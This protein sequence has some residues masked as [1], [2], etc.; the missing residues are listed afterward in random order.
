[1]T[2]LYLSNPQV[3]NS[4]ELMLCFKVTI[5]NDNEIT[6]S[7]HYQPVLAFSLSNLAKQI[8]VKC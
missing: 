6:I 3:I 4:Q 7:A 5:K 2:E 1:M 8:K